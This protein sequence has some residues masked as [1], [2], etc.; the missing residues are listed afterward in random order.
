MDIEFLDKI[1][2][3]EFRA[4]YDM[5]KT[6]RIPMCGDKTRR[7]FPPHKKMC[8]GIIRGRWN[9][10]VGLSA[11]SMKYPDLLDEVVRIGDKYCPFNFTS[12]HLNHNVIC[13]PHKDSK[14]AGASMIVSFGE[15]E[16]CKLVVE[17]NV[18]DTY[19]R[20]VLFNGSKMEHYNTN[21]L[22]GN[23][24][25]LVYYAKDRGCNS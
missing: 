24:Y 19:L 13:P 17:G 25:S 11:D 20:P 15:Y 16:G 5:L 18:C 22:I 12:I 23:K 14:N 9:G 10:I 6:I 3:D 2:P 7:G 4:L 21:D 8:L 1:E